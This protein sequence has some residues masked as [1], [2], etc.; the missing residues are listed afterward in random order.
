MLTSKM[1][2]IA[3]LLAAAAFFLSRPRFLYLFHSGGSD[4]DGSS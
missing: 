3:A 1:S 4:R 2:V